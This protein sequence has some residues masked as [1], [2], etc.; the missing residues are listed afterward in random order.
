MASFSFL[1]LLQVLASKNEREKVGM[2]ARGPQGP[3]QDLLA[4]NIANVEDIL[5]AADESDE[6]D[7]THAGIGTRAGRGGDDLDHGL[8][9]EEI[10]A[11]HDDE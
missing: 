10:L 3:G 7:P 8:S 4:D 6:D 9:L 11:E 5:A 1:L 2:A